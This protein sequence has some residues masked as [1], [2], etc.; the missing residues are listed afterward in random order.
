MDFTGES[1]TAI[2]DGGDLLRVLAYDSWWD[3]IKKDAR[4]PMGREQT[5]RSDTTGLSQASGP[6]HT[7]P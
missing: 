1:N 5:A 2:E 3:W 6:L 7:V 4:T